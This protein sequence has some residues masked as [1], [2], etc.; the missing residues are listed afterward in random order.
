MGAVVDERGDYS[1]MDDAEIVPAE[2]P[3][4]PEK[5]S[6]QPTDWGWLMRSVH[7]AAVECGISHDDLHHLLGVDSLKDA[8]PEDLR[9]LPGSLRMWT[10]A[11]QDAGTAEKLAHLREDLESAGGLSEMA[12]KWMEWAE[13]RKAWSPLAKIHAAK[14]KDACKKMMQ[15]AEEAGQ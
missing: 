6:R 9:D 10:T 4:A 11:D 2:P 8:D 5:P 13:E 15:A 14:I 7:A 12:E 1:P 3:P